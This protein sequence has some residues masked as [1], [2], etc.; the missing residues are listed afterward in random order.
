MTTDEAGQ[1]MLFSGLPDAPKAPERPDA[2]RGE[3]GGLVGRA[4]AAMAARREQEAAEAE[5]AAR[6]AELDAAAAA[7]ATIE[8]DTGAPENGSA[9]APGPVDNVIPLRK[10]RQRK[11]DGRGDFFAIDHRLWAKVCGLGLNAAVAYLVLARGTGGDNRTSSWSVNAIREY[12]G[13]GPKRAGEALALLEK[14]GLVSVIKN[15]SRPRRRLAAANELAGKGDVRPELNEYEAAV[16]AD[17]RRMGGGPIFVPKTTNYR[18]GDWSLTSPYKHAVKLA[19][20]G[21]LRD[22]GGQKFAVIETAPGVDT[23]G[24]YE[25]DWTWLPNAIVDGAAGEPSPLERI[26]QLQSLAAIRVFVDLYHSHDLAEDGGVSWANGAGIRQ[27]FERFAVGQ[28]GPYA[29]WGFKRG[30]YSAWIGA[31][32]VAPHFDPAQPEGHRAK[33]FYDALFALEK[34]GLVEPIAHL[35][36]SAE[37]ESAE[38]IHPLPLPGTGEPAEQELAH[39]AMRA[40]RALV[41]EGQWQWACDQGARVFAPQGKALEKVAVVGILR[42]RY[43]P[44]TNATQRWYAAIS[45]WLEMSE[46]YEAI[47]R[48]A[49][50]EQNATS[51]DIKGYQG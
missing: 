8:P 22:A 32:A 18:S 45:E 51:R 11:G 16:L 49:A 41:T 19:A 28:Q 31:T 9:E 13:I 50:G 46:R 14:A 4:Q 24:D 33:G 37:S 42:L 6:L 29:V 36:E 40:A 7:M 26:R 48:K 23:S 15:D 17:L 21:Y 30:T 34:L 1:G 5:E 20:K 47:R 10:E 2:F 27:T 25:P 12:T 38:I 3:V 35:V 39:A 44:R 43:R